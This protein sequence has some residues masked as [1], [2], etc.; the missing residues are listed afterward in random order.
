MPSLK[1][2]IFLKK[3][4]SLIKLVV[5]G[6]AEKGFHVLSIRRISVFLYAKQLAG[7]LRHLPDPLILILAT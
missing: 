2:G 5:L 1:I 3:Y 6:T 4:L 7:P